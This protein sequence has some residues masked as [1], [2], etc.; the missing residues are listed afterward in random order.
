MR[1]FLLGVLLLPAVAF[2][3]P[4]TVEKPVTCENAQK[5]IQELEGKY[6]EKPIWFGEG[7]VPGAQF[8]LLVNKETNTWSFIQFSVEKN[9]VCLIDSGTKFYIKPEV[10]GGKG[11]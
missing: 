3:Q 9:I 11:V 1:K 8:G 6:G 10:F 4:V 5:A 7:T 2:A